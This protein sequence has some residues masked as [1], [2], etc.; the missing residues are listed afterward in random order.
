MAEFQAKKAGITLL[1]DMLD[2]LPA[3]RADPLHMKQTIVS[4]LLNAVKFTPENES[5]HVAAFVGLAVELAIQITDTSIG[6][7]AEDIPRVLEP[8]GQVI[9]QYEPQPRMRG[10]RAFDY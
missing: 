9:R 10:F 8:F 1:I 4:L 5:I 2:P 3:L 6:I 7:A